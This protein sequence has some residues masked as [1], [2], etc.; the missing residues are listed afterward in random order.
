MLLILMK[1]K[2][3]ERKIQVK[4]FLNT[5]THCFFLHYFIFSGISRQCILDYETSVACI[6]PGGGHEMGSE[7]RDDRRAHDHRPLHERAQEGRQ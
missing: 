3:T 1:E 5:C 4:L 7:G 6:F 2:K